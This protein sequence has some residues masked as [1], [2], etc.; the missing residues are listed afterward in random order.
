[1]RKVQA[2]QQALI[3]AGAGGVGH[4]AVQLAKAYGAEV[5]ATVSPEKQHV[6]EQFGATPID[7]R[8]L[9]TEQYV[10]LHTSGHG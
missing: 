9:S 3:H 8:T 2:G 10:D 4:I 1:M 7:Y 6:V 5:F